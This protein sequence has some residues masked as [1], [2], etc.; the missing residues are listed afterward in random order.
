MFYLD[1]L[2]VYFNRAEFPIDFPVWHNRDDVALGKDAVVEKALWWIN[3]LVYPHNTVIDKA[4]YS[5]EEDT[6]HLST[7]IEN[8]NSHQ[9]S[10][11]AYF[12]TLE[13]VVIDS[14]NL[15]H[16][17]LK[18]EGEL[19]TADFN[20]PPIE[21]FYKVSVTAFDETTSD[22]FTVP[23]ATRFTTA[24][25]VVLDSIA[26]SYNAAFKVYRVKPFIKNNGNNLTITGTSLELSCE[27]S[28]ITSISAPQSLP[29]IPPGE[30]VSI[31]SYFSVRVDS[32]FPSYFNFKFKISK[33]G[34]TCWTDSTN[35]V[36]GVEKSEIFPTAYDLEQNYPNPFNPS[37]TFRYSIPTQSKVVIKV[38]DILGNEVATLVNEEKSVGTYELTWDASSLSSGVYFYQLKAGA[39]VETKKMLLLK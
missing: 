15:I 19:W 4:Y 2:G 38:Y 39:F 10:A 9:L 14:V 35:V 24:G 25:P 20:L 7:I 28:W 13:N 8:P 3:N 29:A 12:K 30:V 18:S 22:F 33:D 32:T 11:R 5:P 16:Q 21:Q 34:W 1:N 6:V 36:V 23:N 27:D 37:T 31:P 17:T 26:I